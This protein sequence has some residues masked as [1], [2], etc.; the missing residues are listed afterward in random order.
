MKA[1]ELIEKLG[2]IDENIMAESVRQPLLFVDAARYRVVK[3]RKRAQVGAQLEYERSRIATQLRNKKGK[4]GDKKVTEGAIKE[5]IE[6]N[7]KIRDLRSQSDR[8]YE[9]EEFAKLLLEAFRQRNSA[10]KIIA[11][12]QMLEGSRE[13]VQI[14]RDL[15][16]KKLRN[17][18]RRLLAH[19]RD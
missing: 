1:E 16:S 13:S 18:A 9:E 6:Q 8:A 2:V 5:L 7:E 4:D 15:Q 3:M 10:I 19:R 12:M 14:E 17:E 11:E